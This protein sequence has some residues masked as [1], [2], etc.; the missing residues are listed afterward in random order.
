[1]TIMVF[2]IPAVLDAVCGSEDVAVEVVAVCAVMGV[3][4][5]V[6]VVAVCAIPVKGRATNAATI[7]SNLYV[8]DL[9]FALNM[10]FRNSE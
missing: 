5:A 10:F 1:M 7:A 3:P 9:F 8:V 6:E 2:D 4:V